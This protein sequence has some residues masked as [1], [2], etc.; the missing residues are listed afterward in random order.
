MYCTRNQNKYGFS[1]DQKE[2][3]YLSA[4]AEGAV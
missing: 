3:D 1:I 4:R 2:R